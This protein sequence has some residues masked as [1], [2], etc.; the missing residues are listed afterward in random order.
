MPF[1]SRLEHWK[2]L[3]LDVSLVTKNALYNVTSRC[4]TCVQK[5]NFDLLQLDAK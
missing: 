2:S 3:E 5:L 4:F 1:N